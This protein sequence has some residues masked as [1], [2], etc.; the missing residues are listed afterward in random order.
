VS[1]SQSPTVSKVLKGGLCSGCGA[2]AGVSD[3]AI[4]MSIDAKGFARPVQHA[5]LTQ[6]QEATIS[7]SCVGMHVAPW[8]QA[9]GCDDYWGPWHHV[10]SGHASDP[11]V[12]QGA[13]SGGGISALLLHALET[14]LVDAVVQTGADPDH[15]TRNVTRI[16][17]TRAEVLACYGSRYG[18]SSPL[19]AVGALLDDPRRFAFVGKPCD[20]SALRLLA[21]RDARVDARFPLM[22]SF[23][24]AGVPSLDGTDRILD[25]LGVKADDLAAFR[26]R[27]DG[28]PGYATATRRDGSIEKMSYEDS[29]GSILSHHVQ[30]R[31][32]ICPDAVGGAADI[33]CADAW[34]GDE[35]GYPL[36]EETDGRSLII[37]RTEAGRALLD[38]ALAAGKVIAEPTPLRDIDRMQPSQARRKRLIVSRLA[39]LYATFQPVPRFK[40]VAIG[41]AARKAGVVAQ[42]KSFLGLVR[43]IVQGRK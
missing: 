4:S 28:W 10:M 33:A 25:R 36:F 2:C 13:S 39:A 6:E 16:S 42:L 5:P 14:G 21:R 32:K 8:P 9:S 27:G 35:N 37:S 38:S 3:G 43:R 31:C 7:A 29:W 40:D 20:V 26:Y 34:Y 23:F 18:P 41:S 15:P 19:S 30:F 1:V 11:E 17:Q 22:L 24:C 12:R